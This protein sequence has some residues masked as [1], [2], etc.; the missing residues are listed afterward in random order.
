MLIATGANTAEDQAA[1]VL[2]VV[3]QQVPEHQDKVFL[4]VEAAI[5]TR[6]AAAE[7][8]VDQAELPINQH[9][10]AKVA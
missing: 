1:A 7:V 3:Q 10:Q 4:A 8:L 6:Q 2:T 5:Q 9:L